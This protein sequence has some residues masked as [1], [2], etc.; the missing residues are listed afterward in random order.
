M[1]AMLV[2]TVLIPLPRPSIYLHHSINYKKNIIIIIELNSYL[3]L[4]NRHPVSEVRILD[5]SGDSNFSFILFARHF[6]CI[7]D[8]LN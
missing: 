6:D 1:S 8:I 2:I 3:C 7:V 5:T 4:E